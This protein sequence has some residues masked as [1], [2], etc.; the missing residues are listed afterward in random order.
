MRAIRASL[1]T[2]VSSAAAVAVLATGGVMATA[3]AASAAKGHPKLAPTTL[4]IKNK[5]IAHARHHADALTGVLSSHRKGVAGETITLDSRTG[6]KPRWA[7]VASG[8]TGTDGSVTFT[9][10]PTAKT[11]YK[12]VFAG[13]ATYRKSHSNVIT[14]KAVKK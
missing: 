6:K 4:S 1:L 10:A 5:P 12:M 11:Q 7:A 3:T 14:L 2:R 9:V 8:T 13:D